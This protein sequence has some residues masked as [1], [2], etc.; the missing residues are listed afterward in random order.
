MPELA[1]GLFLIFGMAAASADG[2]EPREPDQAAPVV[3]ELTPQ[4]ANASAT[5]DN[6]SCLDT[7]AEL[8]R[9]EA[10]LSTAWPER[11]YIVEGE[12]CE[13]SE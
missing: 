10:D 1:I 13:R 6:P 7:L 5:A 9:V 11:T 8:R 3:V 12:P 4:E 2:D